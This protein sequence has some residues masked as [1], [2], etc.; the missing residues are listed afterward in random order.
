MMGSIP[1]YYECVKAFSETGFTEDLKTVDV[2]VLV[3]HGEDDQIVPYQNTGVK[4]AK[5]LKNGKFN[6]LS[7]IR[8]WNAN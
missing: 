8:S 5:L 2:P 7:W 1:A 3:V 6:Y 4:S